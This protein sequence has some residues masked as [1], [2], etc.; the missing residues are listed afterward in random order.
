MLPPSAGGGGPHRER[1][2]PE[3]PHQSS[4][5]RITTAP[6]EYARPMSDRVFRLVV[7][8]DFSEQAH[9]A[10]RR[11]LVLAA[12]HPLTIIHVV[13]V[14]DKSWK[15]RPEDVTLDYQGADTLRERLK[16]I[17][18]RMAEE[19]GPPSV[20]LY[21][22]ARIG[23]PAETILHVANEAR[24]DLI[25]A[26]T[27]AKSGIERWVLG[28]V[29]EELVRRASCSVM[30]VREPDYDSA[31]T[32]EFLPEPPC[33]ACLETRE[34]TDG[35]SW[36]CDAHAQQSLPYESPLRLS[37]DHDLERQRQNAWVLY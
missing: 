32:R 21:A 23:A 29:S 28:S 24:A 35:A 30:I 26:G 13:A 10:L 27:H 36:F 3:T 12:R 25:L 31:R 16:E 8:F 18:D 11:A 4:G 2:R 33:P 15:E 5:I 14:L 22:Q 20:K 7:A 19:V 37:Y 17:A 6:I 1:N 9:L 34:K